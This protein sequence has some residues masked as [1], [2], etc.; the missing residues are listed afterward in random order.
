MQTDVMSNNVNANQIDFDILETLLDDPRVGIVIPTQQ[1]SFQMECQVEAG[2]YP[3]L[4]VHLLPLQLTTD[5][6]NLTG[7]CT[8]FC[9][10][11]QNVLIV[12]ARIIESL[13]EHQIRVEVVETQKKAQQREFFRIDSEVCLEHRPVGMPNAG[14]EGALQRVNLSG[15]GLRF[16]TGQDVQEDDLV[17]IALNFP[18]ADRGQVNAVG[19]VVRVF[20]TGSSRQEAALELF[21]IEEAAQ[22]KIVSFCIAEQLR[23]VRLKVQLK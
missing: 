17:R 6:L 9:E 10:R 5:K 1:N 22:D 15:N 16:A 21:E 7:E 20:A 8:L 23:Q 19:R 12:R 14:G 4:D 2:E 13:S 3:S 11:F 18:D